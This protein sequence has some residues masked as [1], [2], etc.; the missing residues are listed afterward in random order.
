MATKCPAGTYSDT[1]RASSCTTCPAGKYCPLGTSSI[2]GTAQDCPAGSYCPLGTK[3]AD[4]YP[5]PAGTFVS[6]T[7]S[8]AVSDC[9]N[10]TA[11]YACENPGVSDPTT[12][13]CDAGFFCLQASTYTTPESATYG[14][15]CA[16]GQYCPAASPSASP[17]DGG[18]YCEK[19]RLSAVSGTCTIGYYCTT[20]GS[21]YQVTPNDFASSA[22]AICGEGKYC[23]AGAST[24]TDCPVGTY[25]ASTGLGAQADCYSC[26][27]GYYCPDLAQTNGTLYQ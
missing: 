3:A 4:E 21:S 16:P 20:V 17:C 14:G 1:A 2:A 12:A 11:G 9:G 27:G 26:P 8:T 15:M 19:H 10:C 13:P 5:C 7:G 23:P 18:K 25:S 6:T 22:S 24:E